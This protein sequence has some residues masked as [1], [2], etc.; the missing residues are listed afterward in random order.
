MILP[1]ASLA[2]FDYITHLI[3]HNTLINTKPP[4]ELM[5]QVRGL[6]ILNLAKDDG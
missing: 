2:N 1:A 4:H 6:I 5:R 3:Y